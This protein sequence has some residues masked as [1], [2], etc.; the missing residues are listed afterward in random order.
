MK[1]IKQATIITLDQVDTLPG[2]L[3]IS[4]KKAR[5]ILKHKD[6]DPLKYQRSDRHR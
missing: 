3:P 4:W 6:I 2:K 5:G 1:S